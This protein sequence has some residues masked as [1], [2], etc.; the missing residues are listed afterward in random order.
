MTQAYNRNC[1]IERESITPAD[2][3]IK[4]LIGSIWNQPRGHDPCEDDHSRQFDERLSHDDCRRERVA[5]RERER[6]WEDDQ[7][8]PGYGREQDRK[9]VV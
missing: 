4:N 5:R 9:S 1:R 6:Q 7:R 8:V 2:I 3:E